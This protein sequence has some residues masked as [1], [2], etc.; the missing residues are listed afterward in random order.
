VSAESI[1]S[2]RDIERIKVLLHDRKMFEA[3]VDAALEDPAVDWAK[4][5]QEY[6]LKNAEF[7]GAAQSWLERIVEKCK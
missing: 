4:F 1:L 7:I 6:N 3:R 5:N 2:A